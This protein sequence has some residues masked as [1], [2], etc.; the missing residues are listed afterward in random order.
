M[1]RRDVGLVGGPPQCEERPLLPVRGLTVPRPVTCPAPG[2][3]RAPPAPQDALVNICPNPQNGQH[4]REPQC[5]LW[6]LG[7]NDVSVTAHH[8]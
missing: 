6:A 8:L 7:D 2:V 4:K 3:G 5:Q 1:G